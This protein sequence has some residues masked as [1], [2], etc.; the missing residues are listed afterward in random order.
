MHLAVLCAPG[1]WYFRDLR[2][3]AADR[4][5]VVAL[6][7]T[8]LQAAEMPG[9]SIVRTGGSVLSEFDAVLVRTMP[10]GSLE[11]VVFRME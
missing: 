7:F 10:P 9:E 1:S 3:A 6:P 2:R 4:H 8:R 5:D 11:Q